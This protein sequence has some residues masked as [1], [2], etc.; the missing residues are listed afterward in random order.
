MKPD[1]IDHIVAETSR[2]N[3]Q[4][5]VIGE[6]K[7]SHFTR[8]DILKFLAIEMIMGHE[9]YMAY[10]DYWHS[11]HSS[12]YIKDIMSRN[13]YE[14]IRS[15][16]HFLNNDQPSEKKDGFWKVRVLVD[17]FVSQC[18]TVENEYFQSVN[19]KMIPYKGSFSGGKK[20]Y[21]PAK[22]IK[23]GF[24]AYVRAGICGMIYDFMLYDGESTLA[25]DI[26]DDEEKNILISSKLVN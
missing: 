23:W 9:R 4:Q 12:S 8:S 5:S 14:E 26:F 16:L 21:M 7:L 11:R 6:K 17:A 1:V 10:R 20:V 22:P 24:K 15:N 2:Y 13:R 19:E 18:K 25:D 3:L